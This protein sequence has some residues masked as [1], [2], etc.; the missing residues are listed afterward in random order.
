MPISVVYKVKVYC[1]RAQESIPW[2][3]PLWWAHLES[4]TSPLQCRIAFHSSLC[5]SPKPW[6]DSL[7]TLVRLRQRERLWSFDGQLLTVS[8]CMA[9]HSCGDWILW[10]RSLVA[11]WGLIDKTNADRAFT[12]NKTKK[13]QKDELS[14]RADVWNMPETLFTYTPAKSAE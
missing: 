5:T 12:K 10:A 9:S 8:A 14:S 2:A 11:S 6:N 4:G 7:V 13:E 3:K 1:T